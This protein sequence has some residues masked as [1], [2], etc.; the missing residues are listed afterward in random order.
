MVQSILISCSA[1]NC[2]EWAT[3]QHRDSNSTFVGHHDL[4]TYLAVGGNVANGRMKYEI[5]G[6]MLQPCGPPPADKDAS[7]K[8][9]I[10][11]ED[12]DPQTNQGGYT[13][14]DMFTD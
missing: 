7:L 11:L 5:L 3:N 10:E 1:H 12:A 2:S 13:S 8:L 9:P 4:L 6:K 14:D